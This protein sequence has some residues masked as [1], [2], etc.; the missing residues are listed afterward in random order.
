MTKPVFDSDAFKMIR[1][2]PYEPSKHILDFPVACFGH[3]VGPEVI[4]K[5]KDKR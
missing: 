2:H 1:N 3:Y 4:V 5:L